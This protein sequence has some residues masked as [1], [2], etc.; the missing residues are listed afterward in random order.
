MQRTV[1]IR[2]LQTLTENT[3]PDPGPK[4][5]ALREANLQSGPLTL[6]ASLCGRFALRGRGDRLPC[7][8]SNVSEPDKSRYFWCNYAGRLALAPAWPR[9]WMILVSLEKRFTGK[10]F[11]G[12]G[13]LCKKGASPSRLGRVPEF[14]WDDHSRAIDFFR[15]SA[16]L[17]L[18]PPLESDR[19]R[20]MVQSLLPANL[21][22]AP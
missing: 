17:L 1:S 5:K 21:G 3:S 2:R 19:A 10:G 18:P 16:T 15:V 8:D 13:V 11:I 12:I 4:A 7:A 20:S 9:H 22:Q 6:A 14:R